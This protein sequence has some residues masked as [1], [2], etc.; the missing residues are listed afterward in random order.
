MVVDET[1]SARGQTRMAAMKCRN[2][3]RDESE[4]LDHR[5]DG[6]GLLCMSLVGT[7]HPYTWTETQTML[8]ATIMLAI[9]IFT[10][11]VGDIIWFQYMSLTR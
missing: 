9:I 6:A 2:C 10:A 3:G 11:V 1:C 8:L 5:D 4:H 7:F